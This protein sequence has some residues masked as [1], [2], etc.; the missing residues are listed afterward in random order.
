MRGVPKGRLFCG[1]TTFVSA[2]AQPE[3]CSSSLALLVRPDCLSPDRDVSGPAADSEPARSPPRAVRRLSVLAVL[4]FSRHSSLLFAQCVG[5][6]IHT[7][8][9]RRAL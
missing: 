7:G 9:R 2:Y 8:V 1:T 5:V 6:H 3:F 4:G